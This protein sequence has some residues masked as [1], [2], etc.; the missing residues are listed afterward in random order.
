[1]I[2]AIVNNINKERIKRVDPSKSELERI[3]KELEN[4]DKKKRKIFEAYEDDI[5]TRE[6]FLTHFYLG[7]LFLFFPY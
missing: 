5:I 1:M 3:D 4:I 2:K 6:E 7:L